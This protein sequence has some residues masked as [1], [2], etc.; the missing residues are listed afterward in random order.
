MDLPLEVWA[1]LKL[2]IARYSDTNSGQATARPGC[3]MGRVV[4]DALDRLP[5]F[6]A[7][8]RSAEVKAFLADPYDHFGQLGRVRKRH[9]RQ[10]WT[11]KYEGY[12]TP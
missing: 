1:A 2:T 7:L 3:G 9:Y 8:R 12:I 4:A 10:R 6:K 11:K 5:G